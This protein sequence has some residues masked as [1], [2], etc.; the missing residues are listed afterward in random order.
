MYIYWFI[1]YNFCSYFYT[2]VLFCIGPLYHTRFLLYLLAID[3]GINFTVLSN[4][5][6]LA[7][8]MFFDA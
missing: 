2:F 6:L 4:A 3:N 5:R 8:K 7:S 1:T